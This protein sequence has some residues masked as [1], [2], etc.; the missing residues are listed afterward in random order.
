MRTKCI[1]LLT[2]VLM[3]LSG[4]AQS[5]DEVKAQIN[6]IKKK[7]NIYLYGE[8]TAATPQDAQDQA[9]QILYDEINKWAATKKKLQGTSDY[10][11]NNKTSMVSSLATTRGNM[12][13][14]LMYV[15][16]DDI[17][18]ANNA[19]IVGNTR[20]VQTEGETP[21]Q[22]PA[23]VGPLP[24][25]AASLY[26][27]AVKKLAAANTYK[28]AIALADQLKQQGAL[29][30]LVTDRFPENAKTYYL[31]VYSADGRVQALLTPGPQ[32]V[33]VC[34]G[35]YDSEQNHKGCKAFAFKAN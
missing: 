24:A 21:A 27:D 10:L 28:E 33:N 2:L 4:H 25:P 13:R 5:T 18:K 31:I 26:P 19:D 30:E 15:K 29:T 14:C 1:A 12:Y 17:Q 9:E 34:T 7:T 32:R 35:D 23:V 11:I 3:T 22:Q 16:K 6:D 8:S 20:P